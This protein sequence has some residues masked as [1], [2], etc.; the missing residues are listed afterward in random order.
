MTAER[1]SI[2]ELLASVSDGRPV[3]WETAATRLG[4]EELARLSALQQVSRIADFNRRLQEGGESDETPERWGSMLLLERLG[5]GAN[6]DVFRA[7][8]PGLQREVALKLMRAGLG[9]GTLMEEGRAAARVRHAH[10]VTV[11]G[12]DDRDGRVGLWMELI[13]GT[14]LEQEVRSRGALRASE[15]LRLGSQIAAALSA[16][17]DSGL[18]HRDIKP[19]NV[20]RDAEDRFVLADF[21]LGLQWDRAST[22]A[23]GPSGTPMYMAP[24]LLGGGVATQRSDVYSLGLLLWF[25][26]TGRH[27]FDVGT[28]EEL[29][30]AAAR[31]PRPSLREVR[32]DVPESLAIVV[33]K[34]MAPEPAARYPDARELLARLASLDAATVAPRV[35]S[36]PR[37]VVVGIALLG[38][39]AL[40]TWWARARRPVST[41]PPVASVPA[42][43]TYDVAASF[44]RRNDRESERL[45]TGDR[46]KP[47]DRLSLEVRATRPVW[48]Y[49]LNEDERGERYLLFPQ[50]SFDLRNPIPP[51]TPQ[52]LPGPIGGRENAWTVTS[53]G[54]REHFLVVAAPEPV[55]ALEAELMRIPAP[56]A[57]RPIE[58]GR[59]GESTVER[60]RGVGGMGELPPGPAPSAPPSRAFDE[61][62]ALAGSETGVRGVWVRQ[63][64]LE[65]PRP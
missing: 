36:W 2:E 50:P 38:L 42:P 65:N 28:L 34:A 15:A 27:P 61:F 30:E 35:W 46:V 47:G 11:H 32:P 6:A 64:V 1:N 58:Y 23:R 54:G 21:G 4:P 24:E 12:V 22:S 53:A 63:I 56:A 51:N 9:G 8:D 16:V 43:A 57:G 20:V 25:A 31:G 55:A 52:V 5:S 3:D 17:H 18:L 37:W 7:W 40:G 44:L 41:A 62:R 60:L 26:L 49:V 48:I 29:A 10:V 39:I 14:S 45:V 59:V 33:E 13:R 19:A